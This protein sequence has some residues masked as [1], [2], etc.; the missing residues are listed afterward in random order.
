MNWLIETFRNH[1][2]IAI[3]LTLAI[4]FAVGG[5]KIAKFSLGNVTGV[6]LA[7]VLIGQMKIQIAPD[8]KSV[9]FLMFL[10]AVGYS[11]GPQFFPGLKRDGPETKADGQFHLWRLDLLPE[12]ECQEQ[13]TQDAGVADIMVLAAHGNH[14]MGIS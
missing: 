11:V 6:L 3:F 5:I 7:G 2:E 9:F 14:R 8:L 10:L 12:P 4:G 13:A 1:P